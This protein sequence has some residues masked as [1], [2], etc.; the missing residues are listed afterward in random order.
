[1]NIINLLVLAAVVCSATASIIKRD[2]RDDAI[3]KAEEVEKK[4]MAEMDKMTAANRPAQAAQLKLDADRLNKMVQ[5]LKEAKPNETAKIARIEAE[6]RAAEKRIENDIKNDEKTTKA[7]STGSTA[8]SSASTAKSSETTAKSTDSSAK[9][10]TT[11][12]SI[13]KRDAR[14]DAIAM[15]EAVEKKANAEIAKLKA[16]NRTMAA[17]QLQKDENKLKELV[18]ELKDAKATDTATIKRVEEQV[19]AA[20][21]RITAEI[22]RDERTTKSGS[23]TKSSATT[24]K[25]SG[26]TSKSS[27]STAKSTAK[28]A[29]TEKST[30]A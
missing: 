23:T 27:A 15:A 21:A 17:A 1:M 2:A 26:S 14:D 16:E 6:V 22:A 24:A 29:T 3:A 9:E 13:V 30:E 20:E 28:S 8:K 19:K 7:H 25:S 10:S 12:A 4:A 18:Q 5:D 11:K